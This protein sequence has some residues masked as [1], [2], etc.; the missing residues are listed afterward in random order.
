MIKYHLCKISNM[1][2]ILLKDL[3]ICCDSI[4]SFWERI[5]SKFR[6]KKFNGTEGENGKMLI[7]CKYRMVGPRILLYVFR[8]FRI[9]KKCLFN[10]PAISK[11]MC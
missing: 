7:L 3:H 8:H 4:K 1:Q 9:L 2:N 5:N 10:I 11:Y 6:T